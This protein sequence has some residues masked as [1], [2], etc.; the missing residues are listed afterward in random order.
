MK[1][2]RTRDDASDDTAL[3]IVKT[4]SSLFARQGYD[5]TST[6]E[7]CD[8]AGVNIAAI[9]YHFGSKENLYRQVIQE[10]IDFGNENRLRRLG[11]CTSCEEFMLRLEMFLRDCLEDLMKN[12][13]L[14][15][16][17]LRDMEMLSYLCSDIFE[18]T[19]LKTFHTLINFIALGQ[20]SGFVRRD[21]DALIAAEAI[22]S[23]LASVV[24]ALLLPKKILIFDIRDP[25]N[26]ER[27]ITQ[28]LKIYRSGVMESTT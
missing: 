20:K 7:I 24:R 9:H 14:A 27:W 16:M 22:L 1:R 13:D 6:K 17:I 26:R 25:E 12:P 18:E 10:F 2:R 3:R 11:T 28:V 4:A 21:V 15:A 23:P 8:E 19:F 5:R